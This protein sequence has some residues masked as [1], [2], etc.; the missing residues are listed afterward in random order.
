MVQPRYDE[1]YSFSVTADDGVRLWLNGKLLVNEWITEAATTWT[2]SVALQAQQFYNIRLDY[3]N[4]TGN[5]TAEL[6]WSSPSTPAAII[7]ETQLYSATNPPPTVALTAPASNAVFVAGA[8]V[9]LSADAAD[10]HNGISQV[11]FYNGA[12]L[13]SGVSNA[14]YTLT[15]TG[16]VA[17]AYSLTAVAA[18][19]TGLATTSAPVSVTIIAGS[20]QP[21]GLAVR[22][23][24][25]PFLNMPSA[26]TGSLPPTLSQTGVFADTPNLSPAGGVIPYAPNTPFLVGRRAEIPLVG[27]AQQRRVRTRPMNKSPLLRPANVTFPAGSVFVKHFSLATAQSHPGVAPRRLETRLLGRDNNGAVYGVTYKWRQD[28][29]DADLLTDSLNENIVIT[30]ADATTWTQTW[31]YP[32]PADCLQCHTPAANYVLGVKTAQINGNFTYPATGQ[33]DNQLRALNHLGMF[34]PA[35]DETGI[36]NYTA[37]VAVTNQNAALADRAR[38]YLDANCAQCHRPGGTGPTF[39]ARWDTPL[40]NQNIIYGI[41]SDGD[42]GY[43]NDYVV[44]PDD[45]WRS[46]LYQRTDI[47]NADIQMPPLGRNL[48]DTNA[49]S[50]IAAWINSLPGTPALPPPTINPTGGTFTGSV[51]VSLSPPDTNATLY[52]TL[53]GSLPTTNS[54]VYEAPFT[55]T[56]TA[57][58]SANAFEPGFGNSVAPSGL[59]IVNPNLVFTAPGTFSNGV[60]QLQLTGTMGGTC[61]LQASTDLIH[62]APIATN[63]PSSMPF[64]VADPDAS[65]FPCRYYR[66]VELP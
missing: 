63:V 13:L 10:Q 37:L 6:A 65:N 34:Y 41:L 28:N 60:F 3:F 61:V 36:S 14:P 22:P 35:I 45:I 50:V 54:L 51:Q 56:N 38:S 46:I 62:W 20:G 8:G 40:T 5:S 58:L 23:P 1:T 49:L 15:L 17:G 33:T 26:V 43:D 12:T 52:Y 21:Y 24:V 57:I 2:V 44:T 25:T 29:T 16:L 42:L 11:R 31:Y 32:S 27:R 39:D 30:N 9:T 4:A 59:F 7:P 19:T 64:Q 48:V 47:V 18:D 55:L 53:D 66:V